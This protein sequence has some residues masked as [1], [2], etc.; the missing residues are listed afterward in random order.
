MFPQHQERQ[1]RD[2]LETF[3]SENPTILP[4]YW[5]ILI[6]AIVWLPLT[7]MVVCYSAIMWKLERYERQALRREHPFC[8]SYKKRVAKTLFLVVLSFVALRCPFT[9]LIF[10]RNQLLNQQVVNQVDGSFAIL[11][12]VSHYLIF[13]NAAVN[14]LIYGLTNDN[15]RRA[16]SQTPLLSYFC[17]SCLT[18]VSCA[19]Y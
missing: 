3:C 11:W 1:W 17:S 5:H 16:Y 13:V 8:V 2:Y 7:V 19:D 12:Y 15:F 14:P 10:M 9:A 4:T 18:E 6:G